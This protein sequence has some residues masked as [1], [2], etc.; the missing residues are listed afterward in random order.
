MAEY[1][2][3]YPPSLLLFFSRRRRRREKA[4]CYTI[5]E[6][7]HIRVSLAV[8]LKRD[9]A[10]VITTRKEKRERERQQLLSGVYTGSRSLLEKKKQAI[11]PPRRPPFYGEDAAVHAAPAVFLL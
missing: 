4:H 5:R 8:Q 11:T 3:K 7:A 10:G 9:C 6:R 2:A 1:I